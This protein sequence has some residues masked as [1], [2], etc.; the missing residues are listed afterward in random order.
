[1]ALR[2]MGSPYK[3]SPGSLSMV[4]RLA[5]SKQYTLS[6]F[7]IREVAWL[8]ISLVVTAAFSMKR[9]WKIRLMTMY[10]AMA[11]SNASTPESCPWRIY[12]RA[13]EKR[14]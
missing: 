11:S 8:M 5:F 12:V 9:P 13:R 1:M 10:I 6:P 3:W 7:S 2:G 4:Q 14:R